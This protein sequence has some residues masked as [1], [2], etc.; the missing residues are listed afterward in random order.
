MRKKGQGERR[1]TLSR[2]RGLRGVL[3][4]LLQAS[5]AHGILVEGIG[6]RGYPNSAPKKFAT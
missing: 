2:N 5:A 1:Q 3:F 4:V 6:R